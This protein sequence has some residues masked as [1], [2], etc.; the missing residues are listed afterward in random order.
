MIGNIAKPIVQAAIT[1]GQQ[2]YMKVATIFALST[3][4]SSLIETLLVSIQL[5]VSFHKKILIIQ[6][7]CSFLNS[8]IS[9]KVDA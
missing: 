3:G 6:F 2:N 4:C 8:S 1:G 9:R 5:T 7:L